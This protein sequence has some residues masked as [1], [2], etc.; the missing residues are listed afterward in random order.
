M[1]V[2]KPNAGCPRKFLRPRRYPLAYRAFDAFM[3][4]SIEGS[5]HAHFI[6]QPAARGGRLC[7]V[8]AGIGRRPARR[9]RA[10]ARHR[11]S[12]P[13][14]DRKSVVAGK[15]WSVRVDLGGRR[16]IKKKKK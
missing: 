1:L 11:L 7:P 6:A 13:A 3:H 16:I 5:F 2:R 12:E 15:S 4:A 14:E 8:R 9:R 10:D